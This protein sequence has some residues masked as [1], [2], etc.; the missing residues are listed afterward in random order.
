[1]IRPKI[2]LL[3]GLAGCGKSTYAQK[4]VQENPN[5][6]IISSDT[7]REKVFGD[8]ND[9]SHNYEIFSKIIP[10]E[11][12]QGIG[13]G[14]DVI[15]DATSINRKERSGYVK[16]AQELNVEIEC[17]YFPLDIERAKKQNAGRDRKVPEWVIDKMANK[18][19]EP[20]I[21]EGFSCIYNI[22][23]LEALDKLAEEA[24]KLGLYFPNGK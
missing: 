18:W 23:R 22:K 3:C 8:I 1:M 5:I 6:E 19:Q 4:L 7:I 14:K 11:I 9:Q 17:H 21:E 10:N 15:I 13:W 20:S 16:L 2:I 24:D 12:R